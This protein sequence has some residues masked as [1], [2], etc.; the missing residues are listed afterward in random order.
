MIYLRAVNDKLNT[1]INYFPE[2]FQTPEESEYRSKDNNVGYIRKETSFG[3]LEVLAINE[4]I[5]SNRNKI[6]K[7]FVLSVESVLENT[8]N[9]G[10]AI[11]DDYLHNIVKIHGN[12]KSI[13]ERCVLGAEG[14]D[15]YNEFVESVKE[16][17]ETNLEES[18]EDICALVKEVRLID[19]HI[20]S[21]NLFHNLS[22]SP[23][24]TENHNLRKFLLGLSHLFF[25]SFKKNNIVL[26]LHK[27]NND[28]KC[29]FEYETF[30]VAMHSFI[31][32]LTKYVKPYTTVD[33]YTDDTNGYLIFD[34]DSIRIEK[35]EIENIF[36]RGI[37]GSNVP[38]SLKGDGIG[39]YQLKKA[40]DRSGIT[41]NINP[42]YSNASIVGGINYTKNSFVFI[43][44][45]YSL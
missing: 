28:F 42:D 15:S 3:V 9:Q 8:V 4:P 21:Y 35:K 25:D 29:S 19:Y 12:Q 1:L 41:L 22:L 16:K 44:P 11:A 10:K 38:D 43:F 2:D 7:S 33:V 40:I 23:N 24:I 45:K 27:I 36:K 37:S 39:M 18:V 32:N 13:L 17:I 26:N 14:Q 34:M 31:E 6:F 5:I 20:G 30:N